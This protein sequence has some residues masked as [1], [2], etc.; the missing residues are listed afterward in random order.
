MAISKTFYRDVSRHLPSCLG[1]F[2]KVV[3]GF[4]WQVGYLS[5]AGLIEWM[6]KPY[7]FR[8]GFCCQST[9]WISTLMTWIYFGMEIQNRSRE[10]H[11]ESMLCKKIMQR[12]F[13]VAFLWWRKRADWSSFLKILQPSTTIF[14]DFELKCDIWA[15]QFKSVKPK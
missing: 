10:N 7:W 11:D 13:Q 2:K 14:G 4:L 6:S 12:T 3:V 9:L 15:G 8:Q 1:G 5:Y